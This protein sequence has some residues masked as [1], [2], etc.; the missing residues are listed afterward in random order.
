MKEIMEGR[1]REGAFT[2]SPGIKEFLLELRSRNIKLGLVTSGLYEKAWPE[3]LPATVSRVGWAGHSVRHDVCRQ[4]IEER[5]LAGV[6]RT[7]PGLLSTGASS[8]RRLQVVHGR[9]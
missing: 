3:I 5:P 8:D 9:D 7:K 2:P 6:V 4:K 1:G